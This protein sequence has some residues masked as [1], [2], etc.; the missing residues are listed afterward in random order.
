[1]T[2]RISLT[3]GIP[4]AYEA[5]IA[6]AGEVTAA[7]AEAGVDKLLLDAWREA[8]LYSEQERAALELTEVI[9]RLPSTQDVPG[10][11]YERAVKVFDEAQY[12]AVTWM[13][14]VINSCNRLSVPSR[15]KLPVR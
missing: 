11:V 3:P 15:P 13:V 4:K 5:L 7:A 1:M 12:Q 10:D 8:A 9:T 6:L 2:Q 14:M